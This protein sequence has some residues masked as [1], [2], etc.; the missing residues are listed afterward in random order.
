MSRK[1]TCCLRSIL[2][3]FKEHCGRPKQLWRVIARSF[4]R[5]RQPSLGKARNSKNADAEASRYA[6]LDKA[7][8]VSKAQHDQV[9]TTAD[10]S[11]E[12]VRAAQAAIESAKASLESDLAPSTV[13]NSISATARFSPRFPAARAICWCTPAIW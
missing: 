5:R 9:R 8:V 6:E 3:R 13:R 1:A 2:V 7:G 10:V 12:A 4:G 11:R